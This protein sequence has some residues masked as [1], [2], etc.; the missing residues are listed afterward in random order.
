LLSRCATCFTLESRRRTQRREAL[1]CDGHRYHCK[2]PAYRLGFQLI[3]TEAGLDP[4]LR[5]RSTTRKR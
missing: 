1:R 3:M 4:V 2:G 5:T